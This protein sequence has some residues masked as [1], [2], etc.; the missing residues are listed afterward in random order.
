MWTG[1]SDLLGEISTGPLHSFTFLLCTA[2]INFICALNK[3]ICGPGR[4]AEVMRKAFQK[5]KTEDRSG[6]QQCE[7]NIFFFL[8]A[9]LSQNE[10]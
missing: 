3:A 5:G 10:L 9:F 4:H 6:P 2:E 8:W 7:L 1:L